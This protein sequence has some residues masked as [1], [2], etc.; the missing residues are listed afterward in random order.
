MSIKVEID[1]RMK[2]D[3][4]WGMR[5]ISAAGHPRHPAPRSK[6]T[7]GFGPH[8]PS[9]LVCKDKGA[10]FQTRPSGPVEALDRYRLLHKK[11]P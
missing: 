3:C 4:F 7:R 6:S 1:V 2:K 9:I 11:V 10:E 5:L 8:N